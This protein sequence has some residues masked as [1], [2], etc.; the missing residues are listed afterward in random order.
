MGAEYFFEAIERITDGNYD[1]IFARGVLVGR[2]AYVPSSLSHLS[3][4]SPFLQTLTLLSP[5]SAPFSSPHSPQD[6]TLYED[7]TQN[8]MSEALVVF[9]S[10]VN[11]HRFTSSSIIVFLNKTDVS[12][13]KL[14]KSSLSVGS[15][16]TSCSAEN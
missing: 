5:S 4:P 13:A 6:Q 12:R 9:E 2:L 15:S 3:A 16:L 1:D 14:G 8:R 10:P 7:E 11:S